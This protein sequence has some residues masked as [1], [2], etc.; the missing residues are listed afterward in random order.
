MK[1]IDAYHLD[2][3]LNMTTPPRLKNLIGTRPQS[4][5]AALAGLQEGDEVHVEVSGKG[6]KSLGIENGKG[7]IQ[8]NFTYEY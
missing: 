4:Y 6:F 5:G 8:R 2:H 7:W 1:I 3:K